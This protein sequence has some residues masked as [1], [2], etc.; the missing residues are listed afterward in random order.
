VPSDPEALGLEASASRTTAF[1]QIRP[2]R[3]GRI[4]G[5]T[6]QVHVS[7]ATTRRTD[8]FGGTARPDTDK[9]HAYGV[10]EL[11]CF[12]D[13]TAACKERAK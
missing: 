10:C 5:P 7:P 11:P 6:R 8:F 1:W 3:D 12:G 13:G 4:H 9:L 2:A